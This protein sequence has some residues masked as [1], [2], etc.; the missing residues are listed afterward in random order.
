M[1]QFDATTV[2]VIAII[3]LATFV[4]SAIGFGDALIAMGLATSLI[5]LQ[6]ATPLIALVGAAIS[7]GILMVQWQNLHIKSILPLVISTLFGIPFGL[8][9]LKLVPEHIAVVILGVVLVIYGAYGLGG[10]ALPRITS[11]RPAGLFGF[12]AGVLGGAYNT[13]GLVIAIYGTLKRWQPKEFQLT[14][15][16][17]FFFTNFLILAGHAFAGLWTFEVWHLFV[18]SLPV[19]G[20]AIWLGGVVNR[21]IKHEFFAKVVFGFLV[22]VGLMLLIRAGIQLRSP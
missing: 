10:F 5:G 6:T 7:V 22:F 18:L 21:R 16:G 2:A 3:G 19:I 20:L 8:V 11:D 4:R 14:L 13:S 17:Y 1:P 9:L 12:V 15:Q